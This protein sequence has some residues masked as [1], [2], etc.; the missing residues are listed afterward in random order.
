MKKKKH[1]PSLILL[2]FE[3][4]FIVVISSAICL[5]NGIDDEL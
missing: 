3:W 2:Q 5:L 4:L 1:T